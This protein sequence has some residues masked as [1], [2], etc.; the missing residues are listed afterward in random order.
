MICF[1]MKIRDGVEDEIK[2]NMKKFAFLL[3]YDL[4]YK[5]FDEIWR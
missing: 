5:G 3:N 1:L 2:N 4:K